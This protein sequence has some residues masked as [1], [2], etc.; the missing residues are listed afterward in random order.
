MVSR[1]GATTTCWGAVTAGTRTGT[2]ICHI[3]GGWH[4]VPL[5]A[6]YMPLTVCPLYAHYTPTVCPLY[7]N[8]NPYSGL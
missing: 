5:Y 8:Y 2:A 7:A 4:I 6:L 1:G 3:I